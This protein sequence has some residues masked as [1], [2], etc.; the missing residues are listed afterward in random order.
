M[1]LQSALTVDETGNFINV[2]FSPLTLW[3]LSGPLG[4]AA[5]RLS[6]QARGSAAMNARARHRTGRLCRARTTTPRPA[7]RRSTSGPMRCSTSPP[8][9]AITV[10]TDGRTTVARGTD[11]VTYTIVVT[12]QRAEH[13][14]E[15]R[16]D[17]QSAGRPAVRWSPR[18][19]CSATAGSSCTATGVLNQTRGGSVTLL[20]G[21]TATYTLVG[22]VP[23]IAP[24][25][26]STNSV[27][28]AVANDA[29]P[30]DN[31]SPTPTPSFGWVP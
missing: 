21:G 30:A 24:L 12:E 5:R 29:T 13:G 4:S 27:T 1:A 10:H 15:R 14:D 3:E 16:A 22:N 28:V 23:L 2:I 6:H 20:A 7:L 9:L 17:R 31:T 11:N 25:G 26:P 8:D 19:R 18:G